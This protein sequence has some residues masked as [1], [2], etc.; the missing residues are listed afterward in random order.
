M[1]SSIIP[2]IKVDKYAKPDALPPGR[3]TQRSYVCAAACQPLR[4]AKRG[5][6]SLAG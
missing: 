2:G 4:S 3:E 6:V 1:S 5:A